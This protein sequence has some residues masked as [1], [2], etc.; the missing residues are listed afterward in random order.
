MKDLE[1]S[2]EKPSKLLPKWLI[3]SIIATASIG[4]MDA[5]YLTTEHYS[6]TGI[7]C[8]IFKGCDVVANSAYQLM[9]GF[10]VAL[11]GVI[12]YFGILFISLLY[13]DLGDKKFKNIFKLLSI[14]MLP[15]Y[16]LVGFLMSVRFVYL[17][18]FVIKAFCTYCLLSALTSTLLFIFGI[19]LFKRNHS[20]IA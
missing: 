17:Q 10:P 3:W 13:L 2:S 19:I 11:Y 16:T 6:G 7:K 18:A 8:V 20:K 1:L 14:K 12:Y 15:I 4:F 9:F 5:M